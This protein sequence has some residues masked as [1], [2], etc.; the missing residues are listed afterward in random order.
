MSEHL[1]CRP[2]WTCADCGADWPCEPARTDL[3]REYANDPVALG[4]YMLAQLEDAAGDLPTAPVMQLH[5]RFVS[6][7]LA[8]RIPLDRM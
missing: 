3:S 1:P 8:L 4:V 7:P 2:A 5:V 6:W